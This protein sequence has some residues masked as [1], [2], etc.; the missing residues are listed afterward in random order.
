MFGKVVN[1]PLVE[2]DI[3]MLP[4][5]QTYFVASLDRDAR[6]FGPVKKGTEAF[7]TSLRRN[8]LFKTK[9]EAIEYSKALS[10]GILQQL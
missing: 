10:Q 8:V 9:K 2:A 5:T 6:Y 3:K 4:H 7:E 1:R